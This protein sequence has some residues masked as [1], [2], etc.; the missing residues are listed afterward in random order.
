MKRR[1]F[2]KTTMAA[3]ALAGLTSPARAFSTSFTS[4]V[5]ET[6]YASAGAMRLA[7]VP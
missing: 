4:R 2:L 1:E 3:S 7:L 6:T 5:A